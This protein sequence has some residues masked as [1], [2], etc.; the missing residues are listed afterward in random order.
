MEQAP[1]SALAILESVDT[2]ALRS[3]RSRALYGLLLTQAC[4]KCDVPVASDS[5]IAASARYFASNGPDSLT[6]RAM[7]YKGWMSYAS[8][9]YTDAIVPATNS[10]DLALKS[11]NDYWIAKSAELIS[12]LYSATFY[13]TM[14]R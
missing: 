14:I 10:Y 13:R 4:V 9:N 2:A 5:L 3:E 7:F 6:M 11:E 1:D 8:E 12:L